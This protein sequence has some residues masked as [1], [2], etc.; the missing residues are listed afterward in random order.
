MTGRK[1]DSRISL[2]KS[3]DPQNCYFGKKELVF[4]A[5]EK[6][7]GTSFPKISPDGNYLPC[8]IHNYGTFPIWHKEADLCLV[9]LN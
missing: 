1:F 2:L 8:T 3:I 7:I 5:S 6:K 4:N 9:D